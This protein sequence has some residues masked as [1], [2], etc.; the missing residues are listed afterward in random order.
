MKAKENLEAQEQLEY[1]RGKI[2][3]TIEQNYSSIK[4]FCNQY[5]LNRPDV[6]RFLSGKTDWSVSKL[7]HLL[8]LIQANLTISMPG[9][10]LPYRHQFVG[11]IYNNW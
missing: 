9:S 4:S 10:N 7:F 11:D 2:Q 1:L 5:G 3:W 6:I 8:C